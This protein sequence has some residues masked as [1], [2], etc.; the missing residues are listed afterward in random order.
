[1]PAISDAKSLGGDIYEL[2][3]SVVSSKTIVSNIVNNQD[4]DTVALLFRE[5]TGL[6]CE[7]L[8]GDTWVIEGEQE[9]DS[10]KIS[11]LLHEALSALSD[12]SEFLGLAVDYCGKM[13][14]NDPV[15]VR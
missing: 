9:C 3:G 4:G 2:D 7:F 5:Y 13:T 6:S 8:T 1:M 14:S 15:I 12:E 10:D 11:E